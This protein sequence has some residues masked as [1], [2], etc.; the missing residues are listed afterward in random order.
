MAT[1]HHR[2]PCPRGHEIYNFGRGFL[3][4]HYYIFSLYARCTGVKSKIFLKIQQFYTFYPKITYPL[5]GGSWNLQFLV[6][7]PYRC[8]ILNL[9]KIGPVVLEDVNSRRTSHDDGR[10]PIAIGHLSDSGDLKNMYRF[11]NFE[12]QWS[13][14]YQRGLSFLTRGTF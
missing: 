13:N 5:D 4:H 8:Y 7:L 1:S 3:A 12:V 9:V 2:N 14:V 6:F 10:Q 11:E